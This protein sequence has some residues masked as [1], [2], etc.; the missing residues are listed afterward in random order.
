MFRSWPF[1]SG[2]GGLPKGTVKF[3]N[4]DKG[5]GFI[6]PEDGSRDVFVHLRALERSGLQ[7]LQQGL[8]VEYETEI[9]KRSGKPQVRRI[10]VA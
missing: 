3:F 2:A 5:Y 8:A 9:D 6:S 10:K 1:Y 4:I 7:P